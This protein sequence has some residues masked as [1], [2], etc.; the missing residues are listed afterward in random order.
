MNFTY[1]LNELN[2]GRINVGFLLRSSLE[3][4]LSKIHVNLLLCLFM[5]LQQ[6][7]RLFRQ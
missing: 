4:N 5:P 6:L 7:K 1:P 2:L 3:A